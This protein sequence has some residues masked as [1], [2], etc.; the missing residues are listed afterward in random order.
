M[1]SIGQVKNIRYYTEASER[2]DAPKKDENGLQYYTDSGYED[3]TD[4]VWK[5]ASGRP[6]F[7]IENGS[8]IDPKKFETLGNGYHPETEEFLLKSKT[9]NRKVAYDFTFSVPKAWS[10]LHQMSKHTDMMIGNKTFSESMDEERINAV[11]DVLDWM[12]RNGYILTRTGKSGVDLKYQKAKD[13]VFGLYNHHTSRLGDPHDHTHC[14][15]MNVC[16]REDGS[17]GTLDNKKVMLNQKALNELYNVFLAERGKKLGLQML[18]G[19]TENSLDIVGMPPSVCQ[20]FS[21][22]REDIE[23]RMNE[24]GGDKSLAQMASL[25][26]RNKKS[27][28]P[29]KDDL[30][31]RWLDE[32]A[33]I[34]YESSEEIYNLI[35][36]CIR[37]IAKKGDDL[38]R[39]IDEKALACI[40][41]LENMEAVFTKPV[42]YDALFNEM[43]GHYNI[44]E[45]EQ[46][47]ERLEK[48]KKI[49]Q[50][51]HI[52]YQGKTKKP[53][54]LDV[55]ADNEMVFTSPAMIE[56]EKRLVRNAKNLKNTYAKIPEKVVENFI[57][58]KKTLSDEQADVIRHV[59]N[60]DG[61]VVAEGA[62]GTGKSF[63]LGGAV[64]AFRHCKKHV[65]VIAPSH[66]AK[67]VA[68]ADTCTDDDSAKAVQGFL[69]RLNPKHKEHIVLNSNSVV[70]LDEAG[71]VG[72]KDMDALIQASKDLG[73][74][75]VLAGDTKQIQ[76]VS[77][78]SPMNTLAKVIGTQ[79]ITEIKRQEEDWQRLASMKFFK[80]MCASA[81][82]DYNTNGRVKIIDGPENTM[83]ELAN[84]WMQDIK[85]T[86]NL[87]PKARLIVTR[88]NK[89]T[90]ALNDVCRSVFKD[91][92]FI[93]GDD[94][95]LKSFTRGTTVELQEK[96][97][98]VGDRIIFGESVK[99]AGIKT[100]INNSDMAEILS[101]TKNPYDKSN[102]KITFKM[103]KGDVV[104]C[105]WNDLIGFRKKD[106]NG[107]IKKEDNY[108]KIQH[109]YA[110]TVHASQ[111]TTVDR[112]YVYNSVG[113]GSEMTY[114]AM[115]RHKKDCVLFNDGRKYQEKIDR[116][117]NSGGDI[118]VSSKRAIF[119]NEMLDESALPEQIEEGALETDTI[120]RMIQ[121]QSSQSEAKDNVSDY[122]E[123]Q[124]R[125]VYYETDYLP[126][127]RDKLR[128]AFE[129]KVTEL[130]KELSPDNNKPN[131]IDDLC[132]VKK[133]GSVNF[134]TDEII[135]RET[136]KKDIINIEG[137]YSPIQEQSFK[138]I[139]KRIKEQKTFEKQFNEQ[140]KKAK[141]S[142]F[143]IE[144]L[145]DDLF[146]EDMNNENYMEIIKKQEE[147]DQQVYSMKR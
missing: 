57:K 47:L 30:E 118:M 35:D 104:S 53:V 122:V 88:T 136:E 102:P 97:Y 75:L 20:M 9:K 147:E 36:K 82:E 60:S 48:S 85:D 108:P 113:M 32:M 19:E 123:Q 137:F 44:E 40:A 12:H 146:D 55:K 129:N 46:S 4:G 2:Q 56:A 117:R 28:I 31:Q 62:A 92:G 73:F 24:F 34:G 39:K 111:G 98:G 109:A 26:T 135:L 10:V 3:E 110:V 95:E 59:C 119:E 140:I 130:N 33:S 14:V 27:E 103:D 45:I 80:G 131:K 106:R 70:I 37:P 71:M 65:W 83:Q 50:C 66:K 58:K 67:D 91:N 132:G 29:G 125:D 51:G 127:E 124:L 21:K 13:Y 139:D 87:G 142:A 120:F 141:K 41:K 43:K 15:L 6:V 107:N 1:L 86:N 61:V 143:T 23:N 145:D 79:K 69:L 38:E 138:M 7:G 77:A 64:D 76:P 115:T 84:T 11:H 17:T 22:R 99:I 49:I 25:A 144:E 93:K 18:K 121:A 105:H 89:D 78:G 42:L 16:T 112:C 90:F 114:V 74:K 96:P 5:T 116:A 54:F 94:Y 52:E 128:Q 72:I 8:Y 134:I 126:M 68:K 63:S 133:S 101:I 100:E 81:L